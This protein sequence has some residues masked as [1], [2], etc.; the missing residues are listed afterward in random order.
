[1]RK[2]YEDR[3][4]ESTSLCMELIEEISLMRNGKSGDHDYA[5]SLVKEL[6]KKQMEILKEMYNTQDDNRVEIPD[7]MRVV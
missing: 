3:V 5:A 7:F 4:L 6:H 1:M 2:S